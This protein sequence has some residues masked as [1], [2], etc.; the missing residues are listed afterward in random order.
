M[1]VSTVR[2]QVNGTWYNMSSTDGTTYTATVAAPSITSY[3]QSGHYYSLTVEAK[4]TAGTTV[5]ATGATVSGLR[6]TVKEKTP[7]TI[8]NV[9]PSS[10]AFVTSSK[11]TIT[12][13]VT[14]ETN[15][16]G[17][18][19]STLSVKIDGTAV[20]SSQISSTAITRGYSY[21]VTPA[22]AL[23][24]GAHTVAIAV[25]DYDGNSATQSVSFKVDT[26]AP[27]LNV[28]APTEGLIT[29][30]ANITVSGTTNDAT[31]SPVTVTVNGA[32]VTVGTGG[33]WSKAITLS[34][35][36]NTITVVATDSAGKIT[37]VTRT[38]TLD[39]ST[40]VVS[41]ASVSPNPADVG[42]SVIITVKITEA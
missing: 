33:A 26:V 19:P 17:V 25:S 34:N 32:S 39:T 37:T 20:A 12:F 11:P 22:S 21:T 36:K 18:N 15:G 38:V 7:P 28:S 8:T 23:A 16:S 13:N 6:L 24:E 14:D 41:S 3:N 4:N 29:N 31:S 27:T 2:V 30:T 35:G 42:A 9:T 10:G 1:A 5:T 40:L